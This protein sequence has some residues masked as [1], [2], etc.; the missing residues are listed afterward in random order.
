MAAKDAE[1]HFRYDVHPPRVGNTVLRNGE[2]GRSRF[3]LISSPSIDKIKIRTPNYVFIG[4][5]YYLN[6][7]R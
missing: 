3:A 6:P 4:I 7:H 2:G 5:N 1:M